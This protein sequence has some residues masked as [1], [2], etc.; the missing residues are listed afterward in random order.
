MT[1]SPRRKGVGRPRDPAIDQALIQAALG[2]L[3][4][5]G[6]TGMSI[7]RVSETTGIGKTTIYRRYP[8]KSALAVAALA[9]LTVGETAADSGDLVEDLARQL[10]LAN[11]NLEASGSVAL[12]GALLSERDRQ[13]VLIQTYRERLFQP[14][15]DKIRALLK[16]AQ[17]RGE[18]RADLDLEAAGLLLLGFLAAS[19]I[20]DAP[21]DAGRIRQAVRGVVD[22]ARG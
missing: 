3:A 22:G 19:Y 12:L 10:T 21:L 20:A 15:A 14:R 4:A 17:A 18:L 16:D 11:G 5:H 2:E 8:D 6:F 7:D 9:A 13:P 1:S